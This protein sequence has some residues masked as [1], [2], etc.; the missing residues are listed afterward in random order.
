MLADIYT[1]IFKFNGSSNVTPLCLTGDCAWGNSST[2]PATSYASLE[3]GGKCHDSTASL[4]KSCGTWSAP[5]ADFIAITDGDIPLGNRP[6]NITSP[7][8]N[9]TLPNGLS[10]A[11]N[12]IFPNIPKLNTS[13]L[14]VNN[15]QFEY[16]ATPFTIF[17]MMRAG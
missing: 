16:L 8:C 10:L 12:S 1:G 4:Q 11:G 17:S 9:Y 2:Q 15:T 5:T 3:V 13:G 7:Y 6:F 14:I